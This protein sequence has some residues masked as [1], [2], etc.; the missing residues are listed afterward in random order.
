MSDPGLEELIRLIDAPDEQTRLS[1]YRRLAGLATAEA[2][3]ILKSRGAA[4]SSAAVR[5]FVRRA[6]L[7]L[8]MAEG[9]LEG[10]AADGGDGAKR[11]PGPL[12]D[13]PSPRPPSRPSPRPPAPEV[14]RRGLRTTASESPFGPAGSHAHAEASEAVG[15]AIL[16]PGE[17]QPLTG[18]LNE[19]SEPEE[20]FAPAAPPALTVREVERLQRTAEAIL[21]PCAALLIENLENADLAVASDCAAALGKLHAREA[22]D[23]LLELL[24]SG[25]ADEN[26]PLALGEMG[27]ARAIGPLVRIFREDRQPTF[28]QAIVSAVAK[29]RSP[30]SDEFLRGALGHADPAVQTAVVRVMGETG[31]AAFADF[32]IERIGQVDEYLEMAIIQTLGK[33]APGHPRMI[34]RFSGLLKSEANPRKIAG[35]VTALARTRDARLVDTL[36]S[37]T[38]H[39]DRR[40]R[41]NAVE[42]I[43]SLD[44]GDPVKLRILRP[45]LQD[46]DNRVRANACV[47]LGRLGERRA[48][49]TLVAMLGDAKKWYR[50]SACYAIGALKPPDGA[51]FLIKGLRDPDPSVRVNAA[52][53]LREL[54]DPSAAQTLISAINDRNTWIRLYAIEALGNMRVR[55][56]NSRL[57][58]CLRQETSLQVLASALIAVAR[59]GSNAESTRILVD[60]LKHEDSRVRANAIEALESIATRESVS[61]VAGCL[62]DADPR[63]RANAVKAIWKFGE[64]RVVTTLHQM[65]SSPR[66]EERRSGAYALGEIGLVQSRLL[67][68]PDVTRLVRALQDHPAYRSA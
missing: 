68:M 30:A 21:R 36:E 10:P 4:D 49:D 47:T 22:T 62:R 18:V 63:V 34:V 9:Q 44:T 52:K 17:S 61:Q 39:R 59:T 23:R 37:F 13:A 28:R 3:E 24:R 38:A 65:L 31:N 54:G 45:L 1:G 25:S 6:L 56:A 48:L 15:A 51:G 53:A 33:L 12:A 7:I 40:V 50:A 57:R 11:P 20:S 41:A 32:L 46:P 14:A 64:L 27:D 16:A 58:A 67:D 26:V 8:Q 2:L 19:G 42:A 43:A 60:Y 29:I 66:A 5:Y 55:A 35:L